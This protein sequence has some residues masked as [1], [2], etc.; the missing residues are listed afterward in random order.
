[1][2]GL[3]DAPDGKPHH[4]IAPDYD[5][6]VDSPILAGKPRRLSFEVDGIQHFLVNEGEGGVFE[7]RAAADAEK[8]VHQNRQMW[9][10]LPYRNKYVFLNMLGESGRRTR[11]QELGLHDVEPL[12]YTHAPRLHRL[13][14]S[15]RARIF[16]RL[17]RETPAPRGTGSIRL[18][19]RKSHP[20]PVDRRRLHRLLQQP[21]GTA[22]R[23]LATQKEYL[24]TDTPPAPGSHHQHGRLLAIHARPPR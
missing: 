4:Y 12:G 3:P 2:T 16:P 9:G 19:A 1:M 24:G 14:R 13:A 20:Q 22:R 15:R 23:P 6:L 5:T 8:I 17:E 21:D 11:T 7:A 18:R 10:S